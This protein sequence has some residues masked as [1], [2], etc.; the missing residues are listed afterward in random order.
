MIRY[1]KAALV[2]FTILTSTSGLAS[3][4]YES[5]LVNYNREFKNDNFTHV[6]E[7]VDIISLCNG[8]P[9]NEQ[10]LQDW[11]IHHNNDDYDNSV[12]EKHF[13]DCKGVKRK[14]YFE[15]SKFL[16]VALDKGS[17]DAALVLATQMPFVSQEK[18]KLLEVS[19]RNGDQVE[20]VN[21]LGI[22]ML[23]NELNFNPQKRYLWLKL[24]NVSHFYPEKYESEISKL[25][26]Q[27]DRSQ[28]LQLDEEIKALRK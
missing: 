16:R 4:N 21:M 23:D 22:I 18:V 10:S 1:T 5:Q 8:I 9:E 27:I 12:I 7:Y 26:S 3:E 13:T 20:A 14:N 6:K 15:L 2:C 25:F 19:A 17:V 24:S 11:Y 28:L